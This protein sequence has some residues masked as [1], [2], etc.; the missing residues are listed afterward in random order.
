M[1]RRAFGVLGTPWA[2]TA[3]GRYPALRRQLLDLL[4]T[5]DPHRALYENGAC[6]Y[7]LHLPKGEL[8][9]CPPSGAGP[10]RPDGWSPIRSDTC[11]KGRARLVPALG[12][13]SGSPGWLVSD[14]I[15]MGASR[16]PGGVPEPPGKALSAPGR[17]GLRPRNKM[18][19]GAPRA[20]GE[21]C[22][23]PPG[24]APRAPG[25]GAAERKGRSA[26]LAKRQRT[27]IP[28]RGA[29]PF[30]RKGIR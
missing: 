22:P 17:G 24:R 1:A 10:A 6:H 8:G 11:R 16:P 27:R 14:P 28:A 2:S 9:L 21:G 3:E 15:R 23:E 30:V 12:R 19:K 25:G 18:K 7:S 4:R 20:P 13:W 29:G 26:P 5:L